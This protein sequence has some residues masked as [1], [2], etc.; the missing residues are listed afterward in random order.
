MNEVWVEKT[1]EKHLWFY[2]GGFRLQSWKLV[3]EFE[4]GCTINK[5]LNLG[6]EAGERQ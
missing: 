3:E 5:E 6:S 1:V 4:S 2:T